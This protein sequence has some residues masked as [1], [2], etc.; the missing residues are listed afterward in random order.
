LGGIQ[1]VMPLVNPPSGNIIM[2][3]LA[4]N[5][6]NSGRDKSTISVKSQRGSSRTKPPTSEL[7]F[8][9]STHKVT[10]YKRVSS[11]KLPPRNSGSK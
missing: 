11:K 9:P 7:K 10:S 2:N 5:S 4:A 8:T 6:R 3:R 1:P